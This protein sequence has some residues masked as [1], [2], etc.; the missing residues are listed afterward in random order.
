MKDIKLVFYLFTTSQPLS[1]GGI[2]NLNKGMA[3]ME[4]I[5]FRGELNSDNLDK[6][7]NLIKD[8]LLIYS[9]TNR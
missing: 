4:N 6:K 3:G 2:I 1:G 9:L 8:K 5:A 7:I